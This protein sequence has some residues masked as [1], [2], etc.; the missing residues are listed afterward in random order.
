MP[1]AASSWVW[2]RGSATH[3][4]LSDVYLIIFINVVVYSCRVYGRAIVKDHG[5][6]GLPSVAGGH[7]GGHNASGSFFREVPF[8]PSPRARESGCACPGAAGAPARRPSRNPP[9]GSAGATTWIPPPAGGGDGA[10][11]CRHAAAQ[12][13]ERHAR[14]GTGRPP[15]SR[16]HARPPL[17]PP[18]LR[19]P[20]A[21]SAMMPACG[22]AV[23]P[24][25]RPSG[26]SALPPLPG[27]GAV[28]ITGR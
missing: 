15:G 19:S 21:P 25:P 20:P 8:R 24:F 14:K 1:K 18:G 17:P 4:P 5:G 28:S 16:G 12:E 22:T 27:D 7:Q 11:R 3:L 23:R 13:Y 6:T 10:R 26:G 2:R 9:A